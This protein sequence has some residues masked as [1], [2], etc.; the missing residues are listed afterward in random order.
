MPTALRHIESCK[1]LEEHTIPAC[2]CAF[3]LGTD[4]AESAPG[5]ELDRRRRHDLLLAEAERQDLMRASTAY[6]QAMTY[7]RPPARALPSGQRGACPRFAVAGALCAG[8]IAARWLRL[9]R[10]A[11][12][13][14]LHCRASRA[15]WQSAPGG[16][17]GLVAYGTAT[18]Q[19]E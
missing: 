15:P 5:S 3:S 11:S 13:H 1:T 17:S 18:A 7:R 8:Y 16:H 12:D 10:T 19:P 6:S 2:S 9:L 14:H 4:L